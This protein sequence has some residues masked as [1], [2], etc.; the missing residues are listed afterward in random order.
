MVGIGNIYVDEALFRA[1]IHPERNAN[2]LKD[3][4]LK[5]LYHAIVDTLSEA[6]EAGGSSIK[7]MSMDRVKWGC[8]SI[9][10][11]FTDGRTSRVIHAVDRFIRSW[12]ADG[13]PLLPEV[14]AG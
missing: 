1:K 12:L 7:S 14:S 8:S 5:R 9:V 10:I 2:S 4:E 6:V 3:A 13:D 11:R